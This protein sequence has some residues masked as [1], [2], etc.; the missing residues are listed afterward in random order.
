MDEQTS[1]TE[2]IEHFGDSVKNSP[3]LMAE[4]ES[5]SL[6][7]LLVEAAR[8]R[9]LTCPSLF[10]RRRPVDAPTVQFAC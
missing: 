7:S 5:S 8:A 4:C 3:E 6:S 10:A 9:Q 2:L 1:K